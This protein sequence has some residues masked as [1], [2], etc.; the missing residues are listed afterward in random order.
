MP[1]ASCTRAIE[2]ARL[3]A[4]LRDSEWLDPAPLHTLSAAGRLAN[5]HGPPP[6][7]ARFW[8]DARVPLQFHPVQSEIPGLLP[9]CRF[10]LYSRVS[11][12]AISSPDHRFDRAASRHGMNFPRIVRRSVLRG[13]GKPRAKPSPRCKVP[14]LLPGAT[15]ARMRPARRP[16]C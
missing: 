11:H 4:V 2:R 15:D 8:A 10:A 13:A 6:Q 3:S 7:L 1:L 14:R 16:A 5:P 12:R 9:G